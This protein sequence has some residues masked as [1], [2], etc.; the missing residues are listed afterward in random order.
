MSYSILNRC[1]FLQISAEH[2]WV[3]CEVIYVTSMGKRT[4]TVLKNVLKN[5]SLSVRYPF[6]R[7]SVSLKRFLRSLRR[8]AEPYKRLEKNVWK[9]LLNRFNVWHKTFKYVHEAV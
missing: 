3:I 2:K 7:F 4:L 5:R 9:M 6:K 8:L 1:L